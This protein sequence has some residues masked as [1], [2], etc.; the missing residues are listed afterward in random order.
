MKS[1]GIRWRNRA[2]AYLKENGPA[3]SSELLLSVKNRE[4]RTFIRGAPRNASHAFQVMR[5]D[6]RFNM[7]RVRV[8]G[9]TGY[10]QVVEWGLTDEE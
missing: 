8:K 6:R 7:K 4:G 9:S 5:V 10:Y 3:T 1:R 2:Y